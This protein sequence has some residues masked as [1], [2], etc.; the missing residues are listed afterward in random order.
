MWSHDCLIY[1]RVK[2]GG[3]MYMYEVTER[4]EEWA[5]YELPPKAQTEFLQ[6]LIDNPAI[7]PMIPAELQVMVVAALNSGEC[8]ANA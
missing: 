2:L 4:L 3:V 5:S 8:R 1:S 7:L 6:I